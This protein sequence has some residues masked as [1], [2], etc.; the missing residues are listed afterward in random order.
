[1]GEVVYHR[2]ERRRRPESLTGTSTGTGTGTSTCTCIARKRISEG[3]VL[4]ESRRFV[5]KQAVVVDGD[6]H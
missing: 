2:R 3:V 1:M 6:P 4:R 5:E